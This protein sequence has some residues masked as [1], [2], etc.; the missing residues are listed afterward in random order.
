MKRLALMICI[1]VLMAVD[2]E[3]C[4]YS[5]C[6]HSAAAVRAVHSMNAWSTWHNVDGRRCYSLGVRPAEREVMPHRP[7]NRVSIQRETRPRPAHSLAGAVS[8]PPVDR[9]CS[10]LCRNVR[11]ALRIKADWD[12]YFAETRMLGT[13]D[14][15]EL[16]MEF[17]AWR[18]E[19]N[20][21]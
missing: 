21:E 15:E 18:E 6:L 20:R 11:E 1:V 17:E 16:F 13:R 4:A 2:A 9:T 10:E 12:V 5:E 8:L 3:T 7:K 14:H 19:K